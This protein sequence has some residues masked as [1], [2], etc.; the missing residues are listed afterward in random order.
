MSADLSTSVLTHRTMLRE[1][2]KKNA[3][4]RSVL[5]GLTGRAPN[6]LFLAE[7]ELNKQQGHVNQFDARAP[8]LVTKVQVSAMG[9]ALRQVTALMKHVL[10]PVQLLP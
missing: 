4:H 9:T 3:T 7:T 5:N 2:T 10:L 1:C 6:V 8:S